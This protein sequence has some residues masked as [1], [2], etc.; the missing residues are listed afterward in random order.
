MLFFEFFKLRTGMGI[1]WLEINDSSSPFL[2]NHNPLNSFRI[3]IPNKRAVS[4]IQK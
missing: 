4:R 2:Q 1:P 3:L